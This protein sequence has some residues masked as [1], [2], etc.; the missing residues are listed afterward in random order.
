MKP[1][2]DDKVK[3]YYMDT[4]SFI[5]NIKT[6]DFY[7]D[8]ANDVEKNYDT[9][10]YA[11]E[12]PLPIGKNKKKIGLMKDELGENIMEEFIGLRPKSYSYLMDNGKVDKKAK[13]TK[14][15]VIK[16]CLMFNNYLECL[17]GKNKILRS[18][19]RF[20]SDGHDLYTEEIKSSLII[21]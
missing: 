15:C 18:Q 3:L 4:D 17:K 5:M 9:S 10:N 16:R 13:G 6:E 20:K 12:R 19:Q 8:I 14:K 2:Y 21:Q 1:K 11:C 7:E